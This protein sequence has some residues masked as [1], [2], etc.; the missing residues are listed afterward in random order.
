M[1]QQQFNFII[2]VMAYAET[3]KRRKLRLQLTENINWKLT[4]YKLTKNLS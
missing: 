1:S 4:K 3:T 2:K